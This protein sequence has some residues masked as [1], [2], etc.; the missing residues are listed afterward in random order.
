MADIVL[1]ENLGQVI[2]VNGE[3]YE[4]ESEN[5]DPVN[6]AVSEVQGVFANCHLCRAYSSSSSS[7]AS[8][9]G[10]ISQ[11]SSSCSTSS[12]SS[13]TYALPETYVYEAAAISTTPVVVEYVP[14]SFGI[15]P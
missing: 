6:T 4:F 15:T 1:K 3:C 13:S 5:T 12:Q 8:S 9:H 7:S 11:S 10:S 2:R 14:V